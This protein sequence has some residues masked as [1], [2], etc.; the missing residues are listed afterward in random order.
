M[1]ASRMLARHEPNRSSHTLLATLIGVVACLVLAG[2]GQTGPLYL[3]DDQGE[4]IIREAAPQ[5]PSA[6]TSQQQ[7]PTTP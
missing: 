7:P 4:V 3:P 6:P 5:Q 2:C 1:G